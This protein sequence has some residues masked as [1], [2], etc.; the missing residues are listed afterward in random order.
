MILNSPYRVSRDDPPDAEVLVLAH[1]AGD[2][3][4]VVR[5]AAKTAVR[6]ASRFSRPHVRDAP[7]SGRPDGWH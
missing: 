1:T 2:C 5:V 7:A 3:A 6:E 4:G